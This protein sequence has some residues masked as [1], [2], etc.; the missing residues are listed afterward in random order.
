MQMSSV[1]VC[2]FPDTQIEDVIRPLHFLVTI[3][4]R[5]EDM[6][7]TASASSRGKSHCVERGR[8]IHNVRPKTNLMWLKMTD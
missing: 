7:D 4:T 6:D 8:R 3:K 5:P 1:C 2:D